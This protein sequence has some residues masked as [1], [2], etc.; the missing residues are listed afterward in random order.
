MKGSEGDDRTTDTF[1]FQDPNTNSFKDGVLNPSAIEHAVI[2]SP[3][4]QIGIVGP[5]YT[6]NRKLDSVPT[7]QIDPGSEHDRM[8][9]VV[10][11]G[12]WIS[13]P[14]H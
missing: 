14:T 7:R 2:V 8:D 5:S 1:F 10:C 9:M 3:D 4:F 13:D 12:G 11:F 6:R